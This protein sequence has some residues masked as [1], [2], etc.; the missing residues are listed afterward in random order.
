[1]YKDTNELLYEEGKQKSS[2][3]RGTFGI[4]YLHIEISLSISSGTFYRIL[5]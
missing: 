5:Y 2:F 1:M 3:F 4:C